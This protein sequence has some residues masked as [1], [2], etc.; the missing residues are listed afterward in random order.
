MSEHAINAWQYIRECVRSCGL[1]GLS[2]DHAFFK[3]VLE[4]QK[5]YPSELEFVLEGE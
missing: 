5:A 4:M 2:T 3:L 1:Q